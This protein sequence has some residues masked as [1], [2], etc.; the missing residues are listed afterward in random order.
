[1]EIVA[2]HQALSK[3]KIHLMARPDSVFFTTLCFSLRHV[4]RDDIPTARTDGKLIEYS[5][6]FFMEECTPEVRV[7]LLLHETMHVAYMHMVRGNLPGID[8]DKF[9][10]AADYVINLQLRDRG[11]PIPDTWLCE[12]KYR[13]LSVEEVYKILPDDPKSQHMKDLVPIGDPADLP[14]LTSEIQD[15]LIRA[16]MAS[17]MANDKP[18]TIP[19]DIEIFL[20]K[21][22]NPKL[23]WHRILQKYLQS[24]AKTDYSFARPNRRFF[25][26]AYLPS[27]RSN[28]LMDIA[29]A[30]DT[31]GSV[32][33]KDFL[34]FISEAHGILKMMKPNKITLIQF[35]T[36]IKAVNEVRNVEELMAVKFTGRGG[37]DI[38]DVVEWTNVNKPQLL[39]MFTDG[40]FRFPS[41]ETKVPVIWL[42]HDHPK[43]TSR[44]GKVI[45]YDI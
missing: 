17:K 45:H 27:M 32:T 2:H 23:P 22:L 4:F 18:G 41:E 42:I 6:R 14:G 38:T 30:I 19:G 7:S 16:S 20:D 29:I 37:T 35:D 44:F 40:Y 3:A 15:I 31:S 43:F 25:P 5:P 11:F 36:A 12:E 10:R 26:K 39:L 28:C 1:M 9:N 24:F 21:L 13:G 33:D 8:W 34:R